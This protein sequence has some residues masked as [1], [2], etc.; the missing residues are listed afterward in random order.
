[1]SGDLLGTGIAS[2]IAI[3]VVV[4]ALALLVPVLCDAMR[5]RWLS[6]ARSARA[7]L[8]EFVTEAEYRQFRASGYLEVASLMYPG[9][10]YR[11]PRRQGRVLILEGGRLSG[12]LCIQPAA[13]HL[14]D[15]DVVLMHMLLIRLDEERYLRTANHFSSSGW[16][17]SRS[18]WGGMGGVRGLL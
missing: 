3:L 2:L 7:L 17:L 12:E 6:P 14:P 8:R 16:G 5:V 13:C 11:V 1:M 9:R 4:T 18:E 10:V 15:A